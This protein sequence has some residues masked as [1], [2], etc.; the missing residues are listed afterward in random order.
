MNSRSC[1]EYQQG[2][3]R[4]TSWRRWLWLVDSCEWVG[5]MGQ[6]DHIWGLELWF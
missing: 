3:T 4:R 2:R 1:L 5:L 6:L